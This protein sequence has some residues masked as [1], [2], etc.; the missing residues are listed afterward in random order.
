M[1]RFWDIRFCISDSHVQ[2]TRP[3]QSVGMCDHLFFAVL[4]ANCEVAIKKGIYRLYSAASR[5]NLIPF[6]C[7]QEYLG[8]N[9][10]N[11]FRWKHCVSLY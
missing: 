5:P 9:V 8:I 7:R 6:F 3:F 11:S 1:M 4:G 10:V 2:T